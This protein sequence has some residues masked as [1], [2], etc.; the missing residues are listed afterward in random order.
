MC[1]ELAGLC[2]DLGH[3]A[4]SHSFD[5]L[6]KEMGVKDPTAH[7]EVRSQILVKAIID[8][9]NSENRIALTEEDLR[10]IQYFIDP[11]KYIQQHGNK[12]AFYPGLEQIVSNPVHK[13]DVDKMD[14]LL[15]DAQALRFDQTLKYTL[16][17]MGLLKR[18]QIIDGLWMFHIRDQGIVYDLICRRFIFYNNCYLHPDV[19]A[20]SCMITDAIKIVDRTYKFSESALLNHVQMLIDLQL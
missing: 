2:H 13:V 1:V 15:R 16:D 19:N 3:G 11:D 14:Y 9:L 5:H 18:A 20:V 4:Y 12:P 6:L 8:D 17:I 10:L 7:H